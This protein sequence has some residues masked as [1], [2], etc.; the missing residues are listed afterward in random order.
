[1]KIEEYKSRKSRKACTARAVTA[2]GPLLYDHITQT[3]TV[4]T[5]NTAMLGQLKRGRRTPS[6]L[7]SSRYTNA[8]IP[9]RRPFPSPPGHRPLSHT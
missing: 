1:M 5:H 7:S 3:M 6:T 9:S 8:T 4:P 2:K